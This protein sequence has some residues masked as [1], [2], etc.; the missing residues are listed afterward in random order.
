MSQYL[1]INRIDTLFNRTKNKKIRQKIRIFV[2][3][4]KSFKQI[5]EKLLDTAKTTEL[6]AAKCASK[7]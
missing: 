5:W 2:I 7:K 1:L 6:D 4:E 3:L